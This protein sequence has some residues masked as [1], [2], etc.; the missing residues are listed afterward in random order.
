M[1]DILNFIII[2]TRP[3]QFPDKVDGIMPKSVVSNKNDALGKVVFEPVEKRANSLIPGVYI[4]KTHTML[5]QQ[6]II[7]LSEKK[8]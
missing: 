7:S 2:Q 8:F 1:N 6:A 4:F 5:I 3:F